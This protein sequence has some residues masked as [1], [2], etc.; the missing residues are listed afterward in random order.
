MRSASYHHGPSQIWAD[1]LFVSMLQRTDEPTALQAVQ[2][3]TATVRALGGR[4]C[5]ERVAQEY[6]DHPETAAAR[7]RWARA[8]VGEALAQLPPLPAPRARQQET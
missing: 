5:A 3:V 6:G 2:A 4:G 7:M 1:A 8:L